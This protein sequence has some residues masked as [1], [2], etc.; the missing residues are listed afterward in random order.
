[1]MCRVTDNTH[2]WK[3]PYIKAPNTV[4]FHA[5]IIAL[6]SG[7]VTYKFRSEVPYKIL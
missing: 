3:P 1:M 4:S 5:L 6:N 7:E 2:R